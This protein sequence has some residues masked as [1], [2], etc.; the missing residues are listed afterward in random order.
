MAQ[1]PVGTIIS[2]ASANPPPGWLICNGSAISRT[3]YSDLF[4]AIGTTYGGGDGSTT[5]TLPDIRAEFIRIYDDGFGR[6]DNQRPIGYADATGSL[7]LHDHQ[8]IGNATANPYGDSFGSPSTTGRQ[9]VNR[10]ATYS[11]LWNGSGHSGANSQTGLGNPV[12]TRYVTS[13]NR[14]LPSNIG[15]VNS[16]ELEVRPV[17]QANIFLIK[18]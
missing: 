7:Y 16:L 14:P 9:Y 4:A 18:Y 5:F 6:Q 17:N 8:G 1:K 13:V 2:S 11:L 10:T 12:A 3:V 15:A